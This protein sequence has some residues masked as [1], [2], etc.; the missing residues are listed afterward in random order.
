M[1]ALGIAVVVA[2]M[3]SVSVTRTRAQSTAAGVSQDPPVAAMAAAWPPAMDSGLLGWVSSSS[4]SPLGRMRLIPQASGV[5]GG[6]ASQLGSAFALALAKLTNLS[7]CRDLFAPFSAEGTAI[8]V[9]TRY[10]SGER[11]PGPCAAGALAYTTVG[12]GVV[13]LCDG[14]AALPLSVAAAVILH[15]GLHA[16]GQGE[17]P[18]DADAR[19]STATTA[20]VRMAC[21]L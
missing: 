5:S 14:F 8:L 6:V 1:R 2:L 21:A 7:S 17:W 20:R 18:L 16:A 19:T 11:G 10:T 4:L 3:T 15:E 12:G 13:A 9:G